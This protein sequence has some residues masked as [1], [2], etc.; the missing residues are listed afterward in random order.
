MA[1]KLFFLGRKKAQC[2][3][4]LRKKDMKLKPGPN[5]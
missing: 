5:S 2:D 3:S 4:G 1:G